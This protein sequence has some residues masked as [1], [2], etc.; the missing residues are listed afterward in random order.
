MTSNEQQA[1][2]TTY[3]TGDSSSTADHLPRHIA[4]I[5]LNEIQHDKTDYPSS[6]QA[7]KKSFDILSTE[8][9]RLME[10]KNVR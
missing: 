9:Q 10:E 6:K 2:D 7:T 3:F 1:S 5:D 4:S 8:N